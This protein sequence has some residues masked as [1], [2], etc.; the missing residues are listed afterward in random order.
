MARDESQAFANEEDL[1]KSAMQNAHSR[2]ETIRAQIHA[3]SVILFWF[4]FVFLIIT[5]T[6]WGWHVLSPAK[7]HFLDDA[8]VANIQSHILVGII[9]AAFSI[10]VKTNILANTRASDEHPIAPQ[11]E[12]FESSH[13]SLGESGPIFFQGALL[14]GI[15]HTQLP[16]YPVI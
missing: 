12:N 13:P 7:Y 2:R 10:A 8:A 3:A 14:C 16:V 5:A 9:S 4:F 11:P 1:E 15:S 6:I